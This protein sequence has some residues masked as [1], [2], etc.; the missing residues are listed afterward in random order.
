MAN[1]KSDE[2]DQ[3]LGA[4]L[5]KYAAVEP[6]AGLEERVLATLRAGQARVPDRAW[7]R[8]GMMAAVAAVVVVAVFLAWRAER[9]PHGPTH[10]AV[11]QHGAL[12]TW[13]Q[14]TANGAQHGVHPQAAG[15]AR[16]TTR[17]HALM[18]VM[19][20]AQPKLDRFPSPQPLS[21]QEQALARYVSEFPQEAAL[22]SRA[23]EDYEKEIQ[24]KMKAAS[25][26]TEGN[27]SDQK[28]R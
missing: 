12:Q 13:T 19:L 14:V 15:P 20:A 3:M 11:M 28:E 22:I 23:Q 21:E 1:E 27:D 17:H 5:A 8:W 16:K 2:L 25:S 9:A 4:A 26:E 24:Q 18:P 10:T 6:R 7:W